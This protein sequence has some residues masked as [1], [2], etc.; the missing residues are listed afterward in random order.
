MVFFVTASRIFAWGC[1]CGNQ[2]IYMIR[3]S[4]GE[5]N[6]PSVAQFP[7][8]AEYRPCPY[9]LNRRFQLT[10]P[11]G[12]PCMVY[13]GQRQTQILE[14]NVSARTRDSSCTMNSI[15]TS[16]SKIKCID[17]HCAR[18]VRAQAAVST[19]PLFK[20]HQGGTARYTAQAIM[21]AIANRTC[22]PY[23][24]I[25]TENTLMLNPPWS[26]LPRAQVS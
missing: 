24:D 22:A 17:T 18:Y 6:H 9:S 26:K 15:V 12:G 16:V 8:A 23:V 5:S 13:T 14:L 19:V 20:L 10:F 2:S 11:L 4:T 21:A 7:C 25:A 1:M 3:A